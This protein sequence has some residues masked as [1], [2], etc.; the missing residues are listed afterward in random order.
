MKTKSTK[1]RRHPRQSLSPRLVPYA[2]LALF[3]AT[4]VVR[5]ETVIWEDN[6]DDGNA[7]SRWYA[8]NGVW[9]IGA[10]AFPQ[11]AFT[12]PDCATTSLTSS[13]L[14]NQDSR[15]IR[16]ASFIVPAADDYSVENSRAYPGSPKWLRLMRMGDTL[17]G[18]AS[19]SG[20]DWGYVWF[21]TVHLT[22]PVQV[23]L[24]VT[25]HSYGRVA[26]ATFDNVSV[27][28]LTP[29]ASAQPSPARVYLGGES[30]TAAGLAPSG[31]FEMLLD[32][33][34]G[35]WL[36]QQGTSNLTDGLT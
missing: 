18:F 12:A 11:H 6:F 21:S 15:L 3:A 31:G 14:P 10:P 19:T 26:T 28:G 23:G 1:P 17:A 35:G 27:G 9:R 33:Q 36:R 2:L 5:A 8:E 30:L 22:D 16:I 32:G 24:V 13:Y 4:M 25:S 29:L 34:P 20:V 7:D